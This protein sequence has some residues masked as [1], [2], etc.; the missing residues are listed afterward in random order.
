MA[1]MGCFMKRDRFLLGILV[2][3][4]VMVI[5]A[6]ILFFTRQGRSTYGDDS[7]PAG[8]LQNYLLAVQKQDYARAYS[9]LADSPNKPTL[10]AFEQ[11]FMSYQS[12][13][14]ANS[15]VEIGK[16]FEDPQTGTA[17]V[18]VSMLQGN[19]GLFGNPTR[20]VISASLV[21]QNGAWK[22]VS[23]PYPYA[24]QEP[25]V[26]APYKVPPTL[27]PTLTPTVTTSG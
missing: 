7:T 20:A 21:R 25:L 5:V 11:P 9:Y 23:A 13:E 10:L 26:P 17:T 12:Q 3:I 18:Q 19:Q 16:V 14:V 15:A 6:L 8:A 4:G 22:V 2:G 24:S 27:P 1:G